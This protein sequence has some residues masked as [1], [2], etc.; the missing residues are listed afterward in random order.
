MTLPVLPNIMVAPNGAR[1]GYKDHPALPVT[2][3]DIVA[4]AKACF[5]AGADGIHLH[6]RD[7]DGLHLL[8]VGRYQTLLDRLRD[9]VPDLYLQVTS[10]AAGRYDTATQ[11]QI[12]RDLQ[13]DHVSVAMREM[14][15]EPT[16]WPAATAFYEWAKQADVHVQ[17]IVYSQEE[18]GQFIA[19]CNAGQIPG[20]HHL[21]QL[22]LGTYDGTQI[23]EPSALMGFVDQMAQSDLD[24]DWM[25]CAFGKEET[26]CL[27]QAARLGGKARVGFENSLWHADGSVA[28]DNAAR[29]RT[30]SDLIQAL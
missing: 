21:M 25:L 3:D 24:F 16:D 4:N 10:E 19:A 29:V 26:D 30:V 27:V 6:I 1:R 13:P 17:H 12:I 5:A 22:V 23:S 9:A 20:K 14:V 11:Q 18:L 2:D 8:D 15:R 28:Q 7:A